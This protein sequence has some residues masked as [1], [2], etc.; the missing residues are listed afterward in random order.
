MSD[1]PITSQNLPAL[2]SQLADER[3][4]APFLMPPEEAKIKFQMAPLVMLAR[5]NPDLQAMDFISFVRLA[6]KTGADPERKHIHLITAR[7]KIKV[8]DANAGRL[9]EQWVT[10]GE[11]WFSYHFFV[12]KA[13]ETGEL[14]FLDVQTEPCDYLNPATGQLVKNT[15]KSTATCVRRSKSGFEQKYIYRAYF[16]EFVK[17]KEIWSNGQATGQYQVTEAWGTKPYLMN[18]KCA[19]ANVLRI[20]FENELAGMYIP[21]EMAGEFSPPPGQARDVSPTPPA[22]PVEVLNKTVNVD[23]QPPP[24]EA[25]SQEQP[26]TEFHELGQA[27]EQQIQNAQQFAPPS[28]PQPTLTE[29]LEQRAAGKIASGPA[30]GRLWVQMKKAA[31]RGLLNLKAAT[32]KVSATTLT[33]QLANKLCEM[34]E[35]GDPSWFNASR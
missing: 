32:D 34:L 20:G 25:E 21:E 17:T 16:P 31:D 7:K 27:E 9:V 22:P 15:I 35:Q 6:Q 10:K 28:T 23:T 5:D 30:K 13:Q 11:A 8:W 19:I 4:L 2:T 26:D 29:T 1:A 12:G 14:A 24:A 33:E 3:I 18:E